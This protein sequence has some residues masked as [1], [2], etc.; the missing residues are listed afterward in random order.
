MGAASGQGACVAN[1]IR[2][3]ARYNNLDVLENGYGINLIPL[4]SLAMDVYGDDPCSCF[5]IHA[6]DGLDAREESLNMKMHKAIAIIQFKL[7]GRVIQRRPEFCMDKRLL[8]DKL[9]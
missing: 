8:L 7:E 2:L 5:D 1:V 3:C 6:V 9:C 4:A